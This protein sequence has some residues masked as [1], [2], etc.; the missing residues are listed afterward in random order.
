MLSVLTTIKFL[1]GKKEKEIPCH[2]ERH[3]SGR[4]SIKSD[5]LLP[6]ASEASGALPLPV[7]KCLCSESEAGI[8]I[9]NCK[10]MAFS[11]DRHLTN[12][13]LLHQ[14]NPPPN[15]PITKEKRSMEVGSQNRD[16]GCHLKYRSLVESG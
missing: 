6:Q 9:V 2:M 11:V 5:F 10:L 8:A 7:M 13:C 4:L 15:V 3:L 16:G 1:K 12:W 14:R